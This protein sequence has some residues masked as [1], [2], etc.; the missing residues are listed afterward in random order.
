MDRQIRKR[1]MKLSDY[2]IS[3]AKYT[4]LR[5]FCV[6]Y[7]EKKWELDHGYG[8]GAV[9]NDGMPKGNSTGNPTEQRAIR[10]A[11]LQKDLELIEQTAMEADPDIYQWL[12]KNVTE[13]IPY[14]QLDVPMN[15]T[16]FYS[17]RKYF[18]YLLSL[19]R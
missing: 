4:E 14:E 6:Q 12:M 16:D 8:L 7:G 19:K 2:N 18:F 13:R 9:I 1:D 15:R 3:D 17:T 10:N 5:F 11:M